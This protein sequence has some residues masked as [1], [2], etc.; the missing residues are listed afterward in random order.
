MA[1]FSINKASEIRGEINLA[2]D[3]SITHR[4]IMIG[5]ITNGLTRIKNFSLSNDCSVTIRAFQ[6]MGVAIE[7]KQNELI[8]HG[9]GFDLKPPKNDLFMADS[10]TSIRLLLGILAG[11]NFKTSLFGDD[12]LAKRPMKRVTEPLRLM[13]AKITG[14]QD[15]NFIPITIEGGKLRSIEYTTPAASAQIKSAILLAG[16][17]ADKTTRVTEPAKSRDH[18]ERML[19]LFGAKIDVDN[20]TVSVEPRPGLKPQSLTIPGDISSAAFFIVG[21]TIVKNSELTIKSVSLNPTRIGIIN[22]I[23]K[24]GGKIDVVEKPGAFEP[25]GDIIIKSSQLKSITIE[26][27]EIPSLIDELPILMVAASFA[28]G[29]TIIRSAGELRIK[30]TDR[31]NSMLT[32]LKSLGVDINATGD[33]IVIVGKPILHGGKAMSFN[34]HRTVMAMAIAGLRTEN[35]VIIDDIDCIKKSFPDFFDKLNGIIK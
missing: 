13:G 34:D 28:D 30:E 29:T 10:G 26:K 22:A 35:D 7:N 4:A 27:D 14:P 32:N 31:I 18:T 1:Q 3:K 23:T 20:L 2:G 12:G 21:A 11:Q 16:L 9:K 6:D 15:A 33:D 8:I 25:I 5:A 19:K 24:M 17:F